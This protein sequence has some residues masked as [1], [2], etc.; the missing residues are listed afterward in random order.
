MKPNEVKD[1]SGDE[2]DHPGQVEPIEMP[3]MEEFAEVPKVHKH[4]P[5]QGEANIYQTPIMDEQVRRPNPLL[6]PSSYPQVM[7]KQL[8]KYEGLLKLQLIEIELRGRPPYYEVD[9]A[10]EKYPFTMMYSLLKS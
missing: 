3:M 8:P 2:Q 6:K 4:I 7:P 10:I 5:K 1:K 9:K